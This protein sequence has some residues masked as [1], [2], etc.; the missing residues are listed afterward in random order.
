MTT[1]TRNPSKRFPR[2]VS[3][4]L[5]S[6]A[7]G[8][9]TA[10]GGSSPTQAGGASGTFSLLTY[11]V[12]GLPQGISPSNPE[13]NMPVISGLL[14]H[15]D[16]ALVQEDFFY[17][18]ELQASARHQQQSPPKASKADF[19]ASDGLN[20][21]SN[22]P[23][24]RF[25]RHEWQACSNASGSDCLAAKGFSV[26]TAK[27]ADGLEIDIYNVHLDAGGKADDLQA[28]AQQITQLLQ[29]IG[30]RSSG[31]AVVVAGDTN[32]DLTRRPGDR[33]LFE[34]L[35]ATAG[36]VDVCQLQ[37]CA[38]ELVDRVMFRGSDKL[39]LSATSWQMDP[40]FVDANGQKLSDHFAIGVEFEWETTNR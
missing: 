25:A 33:T 35:T 5:T 13:A 37:E 8:L 21:F 40:R 4:A 23:F 34:T 26:A 17:H 18:E 28:R 27:L 20:R 36:L 24:A 12:A 39:K 2:T 29:M 3:A 16:I 14:N 31:K 38:S 6:L 11:N 10:C 1:T 30:A 15:Y 9:L 22:L 7:F 19:Q 32:L